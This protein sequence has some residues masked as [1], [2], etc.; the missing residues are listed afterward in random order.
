MGFVGTSYQLGA[1]AG[2]LLAIFLTGYWAQRLNGDWRVAFLV[3]AAWLAAAGILFLVL[4]RDRPE[5]AGLPPL[6]G[7][8][9]GTPGPASAARTGVMANLSATLSNPRLWIVAWSFFLLDLNR[10]GFVNWLPAYV[11]KSVAGSASPLLADFK[12]IMA[13]CIHPLAGSG[14]VIVCGWATDR[15]FGGRRAP[16][17][18]MALAGLGIFTF[19]F[20]A[21]DP[22]ETASLVAVTA[23]IGFCTYGAHILMV[24]HAAQDFG[25]KERAAGAAGFIDALGY[26]GASIA[27]WGAGRLIDT[28]GFHYAFGAAGVCALA[29][30]ALICLLWR[31]GPQPAASGE[32]A[33]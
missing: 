20:I 16:V 26:V 2:Q 1:A 9:A 22:A 4:I 18:A 6:E 32:G 11:D 23:M 13:I 25:R 14:G 29:G 24:G 19:L 15:F 10:Y 17:I 5:D 8:A 33:P 30:A 12:R 28:R 27:G 31:A 3:P 21:V 7:A